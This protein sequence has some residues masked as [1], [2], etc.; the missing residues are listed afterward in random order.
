MAKFCLHYKVIFIIL[1][2]IPF[3]FIIYYLSI[4]NTHI[5]DQ[6][7]MNSKSSI[8]LPS[9]PK[10]F[11]SCED[12]IQHPMQLS[13]FHKVGNPICQLLFPSRIK[14]IHHHK[15]GTILSRNLL[16]EIVDFCQSIWQGPQQHSFLQFIG[17]EHFNNNSNKNVITHFHFIRD[18][19]LTIISAFHYHKTCD[20]GFA[21]H[22]FNTQ[23]IEYAKQFF[24]NSTNITEV[25]QMY[26]SLLFGFYDDLNAGK[27]PDV[28][29]VD[30]TTRFQKRMLH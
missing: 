8:N 20:E 15:T 13:S 5:Q 30:K 27:I 25:R 11:T 17:Y 21:T 3:I 28:K 4:I 9:K 6:T 23:S 19:V 22:P 12:S 16:R 14:F 10:Q 2:T 26:N 24:S 7:Q 29:Y 18:P 1:F